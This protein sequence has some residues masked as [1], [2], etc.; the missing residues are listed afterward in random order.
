MRRPALPDKLYFRIGEVS[1]LVGVAPHVLRYWETEF[2]G[3]RPEKSPSGQRVYARRDVER[4]L[5]IHR[6]VRDLGYTFDGARREL[7]RHDAPAPT[8]AALPA[9]PPTALPETPPAPSGASPG[10][11]TAP[12]RPAE[13]GRAP[14]LRE[15]LLR[16]RTSLL[17][18]LSTLDGGAH[19]APGRPGAE[20]STGA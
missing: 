13:P 4:L 5:E 15:G 12:V 2:P 17:Q 16:A 11:P 3:V 20:R 10:A 1:A 18:A 14:R 9:A 6:L 8:P 19:D 7:L